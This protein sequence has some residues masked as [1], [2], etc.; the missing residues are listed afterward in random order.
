M[1]EVEYDDVTYLGGLFTSCSC[2]LR[3][4]MVGIAH[5]E[6]SVNRAVLVA[7]YRVDNRMPIENHTE[8]G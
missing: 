8:R 6:E 1:E 7:T 4:D 5:G 2:L 3:R